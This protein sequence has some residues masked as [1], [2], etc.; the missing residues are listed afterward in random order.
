VNKDNSIIEEATEEMRRAI[1]L[2]AVE[3]FMEAAPQFFLQV[4]ASDN[5]LSSSVTLQ[6][7]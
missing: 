1:S 2:K 6:A 4:S 7:I 5:L 3:A